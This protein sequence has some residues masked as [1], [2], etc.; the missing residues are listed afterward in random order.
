MTP[1]FAAAKLHFIWQTA[2]ISTIFFIP[3]EPF[4][5]ISG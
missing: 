1:Q 2:K 5:M 4:R 3:P